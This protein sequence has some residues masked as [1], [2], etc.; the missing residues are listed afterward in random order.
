MNILERIDAY[1]NDFTQSEGRIAHYIKKNYPNSLL[2]SA[3]RLAKKLGI[4]TSTVVRFFAKLNY[5]SF[6]E[7]QD[8]VRAEVSYGPASPAQ[9]AAARKYSDDSMANVFDRMLD[10]DI[11]NIDYLRANID[12]NIFNEAVELLIANPKKHIYVAGA[13]NSGSIA[14]FFAT[15]LTM[16]LPNVHLLPADAGLLADKML[17]VT[18]DDVL[19]ALTIR[20]YSENVVRT[21]QYF[22][23]I[24]AP[25]ISITDS[26]NSPILPYSTLGFRVFTQSE[27]PFDSYTSV[28]SLC[29]ALVAAVVLKNEDN[30][31]YTLNKG[32]ELW[33][34][35]GAFL[36]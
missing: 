20:R 17:W 6:M 2:G 8:E 14:H 25:V 32:D 33:D 7:V 30:I 36:S 28:L 3:T 9:R 19:V 5:S 18:P 22:D 4:S 23:R 10:R 21:A 13:K 31:K 34:Y 29:H 12:K 35:F 1:S 11:K 16:C 24:S 27:S 15:H 26:Q